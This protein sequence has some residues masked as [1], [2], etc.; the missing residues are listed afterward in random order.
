MPTR[1]LLLS[2]LHNSEPHRNVLIKAL[3]GAYVDHNIFVD[4]VEQLIENI[5][6]GTFIAFT[7]EEIPPKGRDSTK[8]LYIT[9]KCKS[10]IMS[11][12]LFN[13]DS[14]L[15]VIPMS[16]LSRLPID[17]SYMKKSHMM[18]RTFDG[19]KREVMGNIELPI[20]VR[21]CTFNLEFVVIDI[22]PSYNYLLGR[23]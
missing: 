10:H 22:N 13:N 23:S 19:T 15:N 8:A 7:D 9:L 18:V 16:T 4:G 12:A 14:S 5:T 11:R 20:Q 17:L 1:I 21:P 2:L 6:E 3:D